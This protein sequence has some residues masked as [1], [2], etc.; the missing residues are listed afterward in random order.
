MTRWILLDLKPNGHASCSIHILHSVI[1]SRDRKFNLEFSGNEF[2]TDIYTPI[3]NDNAIM[4]KPNEHN[5]DIAKYAL[6]Y[7]WYKQLHHVQHEEPELSILSDIKHC[8]SEI[9]YIE[10]DIETNFKSILTE[11][12]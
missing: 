9:D 7:R 12:V 1:D 2:S 8:K 10:W 6:T 11:Y 3:W 5:V 4:W